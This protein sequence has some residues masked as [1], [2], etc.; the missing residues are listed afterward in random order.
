MKITNVH[1]QDPY[2]KGKGLSKSKKTDP[3]ATA[4]KASKDTIDISILKEEADQAH[5]HLRQIV[6]DLLRRQ[7]YELHQLEDLDPEDIQV[8]QQARDEAK[9]MIQEGGPLS[10]EKVSDRIVNFAKS[11]SNND[12]SRLQVLKDAIEEGFEQAKDFFG[13]ELPE[14]SQETYDLI[15]EKLDAWEKEA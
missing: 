12:S 8:D 1:Q 9:Q 2:M 6:E 10:P 15:H 5:A 7:G 11:I 14:I 3:E 13:G 4:I